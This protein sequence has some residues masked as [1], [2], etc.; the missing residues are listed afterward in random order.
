M[1]WLMKISLQRWL[2]LDLLGYLE[3][4]TTLAHHMGS[5]AVFTKTQSKFSYQ[6]NLRKR[7]CRPLPNKMYTVQAVL[8]VPSVRNAVEYLQFGMISF[9]YLTHWA[10]LYA[11][12]NRWLSSLK[13][14]MC[15]ALEFSFWS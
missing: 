3:D 8:L 2:M 15:T 12:Y 9:S 14:V 6:I 4:L 7:V 5:I 13:A 11:G 1:C 10:C